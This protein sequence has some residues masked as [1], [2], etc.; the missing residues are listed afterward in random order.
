MKHA[1]LVVAALAVTSLS[2]CAG[3]RPA[4][5]ARPAALETV[6]PIPITGIGGGEKGSFA[7]GQNAGNY[8]RAATKLSFF[9]LFTMR[10]GGVSFTLQGADFQSGLQV[11]C[12]MRER[13]VTIDVVEFKP[14]PMAL[15]CDVRSGGQIAPAMLEVQ[16]AAPDFTNREQRRGRVM[17]DGAALEIRSIHEMAGSPFPTAAPMGY[18]FERNGVALGG[19]DLNNGP[20]VFEAA[21]ASEADRKAVLLAAVALSVFWDP[22]S[23]DA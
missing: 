12:T 11:A 15:G 10:D 8:N 13:S 19:V 4:E 7:V 18:V 6:T 3:L 17:I 5:M 2:A 14:A 1:I 22:A 16:E 23:L 9:D 21:G 20:S